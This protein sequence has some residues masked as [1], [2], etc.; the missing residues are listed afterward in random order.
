M[1]KR[2]AINLALNEA[3]FARGN[4]EDAAHLSV[5]IEGGVAGVTTVAAEC[6]C[7]ET[8]ECFAWIAARECYWNVGRAITDTCG[9]TPQPGD[10]AWSGH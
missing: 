6:P 5:G 7:Q 1:T 9:P 2:G 3:E 8:L 10:G 4:F